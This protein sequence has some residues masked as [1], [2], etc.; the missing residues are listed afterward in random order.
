[1][2]RVLHLT[3]SHLLTRPPAAPPREFGDAVHLLSG[4]T[5]AEA[6]DAVC[7]TAEQLD[8]TIDL[9]IHTG[10]MTDDDG[11]EGYRA[12]EALLARFDAPSLVTAGNH[13]DP[14]LVE[15]V[16]G[17]AAALTTRSVDVDGWR[18]ILASSWRRGHHSGTFGDDTLT[19][20][21]RLL[22]F[23]GPVLI[24]THH[25]P[26]TPCSH[27]DCINERSAEFLALIDRAEN[28]RA[29]VAGHLHL[30]DEIV[31]RGVRHF[32]SP[33]TALQLRHIHPLES[34]NND[35]TPGGARIIDLHSDGTLAT[36]LIWA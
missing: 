22:E 31:R 15:A 20:L 13:D 32:V 24:G 9:V 14:N 16:F 33:S 26:L 25:P 7:D 36:E 35:A 21:A 17:Q 11:I 1:M 19:E 28:V 6:A 2:A 12:T 4:R 23:D 10:D 30:A 34:N 8:P 18:V 27:P 5:P 3:D 29:V